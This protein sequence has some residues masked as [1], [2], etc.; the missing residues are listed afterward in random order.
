MTEFD[1][2]MKSFTYLAARLPRT[3]FLEPF[4]D[5]AVVEPVES[6]KKLM[7]FIAQVQDMRLS[8]V[9][10]AFDRDA[11]MALIQQATGKSRATENVQERDVPLSEAEPD[12]YPCLMVMCGSGFG[13]FKVSVAYFH[14]HRRLKSV[15]VTLA[16]YKPSKKP[17]HKMCG[18]IKDQI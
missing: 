1:C 18:A 16:Y 7:A 13:F 9:V 6:A 12:M 3:E 11:G 2:F 4:L 17:S 8:A 14:H 5:E 15:V 10:D